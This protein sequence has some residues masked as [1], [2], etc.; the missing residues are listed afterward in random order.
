MWW[1]FAGI[2][3]Y[4]LVTTTDQGWRYVQAFY[5]LPSVMMVLGACFVPESPKWLIA[6]KR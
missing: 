3:G 1:Q 2:I 4:G 5:S 6:R